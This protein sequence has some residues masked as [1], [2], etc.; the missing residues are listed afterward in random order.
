[1]ADSRLI[2]GLSTSSAIVVER[3]LGQIGA[4]VLAVRERADAQRVAVGGEHGN[5]L[6][7]V[8]RRGAVH[9]GA[10]PRLELPRALA[11]A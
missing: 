10:E 1:M 9:H 6:A 5:A 11:R 3:G 7:H 4:Q 2:S 8:L